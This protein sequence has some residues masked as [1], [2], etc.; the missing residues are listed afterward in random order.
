MQ[1]KLLSHILHCA[2][3]PLPN[4]LNSSDCL[5]EAL[6]ELSPCFPVLC[7]V[8]PPHTPRFEEVLQL[9]LPPCCRPTSAAFPPNVGASAT[10]GM[11]S[12]HPS[13][14]R[15]DQPTPT[16]CVSALPPSPP[17]RP[18]SL[19]RPIIPLFFGATP[20]RTPPFHQLQ[21]HRRPV[22]FS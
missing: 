2:S 21:G 22:P 18:F 1:T 5:S 12:A 16:F 20:A 13:F 17:P 15:H 3:S 4:R 19:W 10:F 9:I 7:A 14:S 8:L 6:S 11:S